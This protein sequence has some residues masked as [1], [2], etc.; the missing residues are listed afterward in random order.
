MVRFAESATLLEPGAPSWAQR[1]GLRLDQQ[2]QPIHPHAPN[3]I[4]ASEVAKLPPASMWRNCLCVVPDSDALVWSDGVSWI[5]VSGGLAGPPGADSTVPGPAGPPGLTGPPGPT[6]PA[7]TVPGPEGPTGPAGP[8]GADST[9][10]GPAGPKGDTGATGATGPVSTVPGPA[11]PAGPKGDTGPTGAD[12]TVPGPAGPPGAIGPKG[13]TGATGAASTVTGPPGATGPAGVAGPAGPTGATGPAGPVATD[14]VLAPQFD[15]DTSIASTAWV[16]RV[17]HQYSSY[18]NLFANTTLTAAHIGALIQIDG[19][20][21]VLTL[22]AT[23]AI[24]PAAAINFWAY[25]GTNTAL[26]KRQ[27]GEGIFPRSACRVGG[28]CR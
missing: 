26:F 1:L 7:S 15:N 8:K 2:F 19:A 17:G 27:R 11:G 4:Y 6:G 21:T 3:E 25:S 13:D 10:P 9:V 14:A 28:A 22:P 16:N 20:G 5:S 23:G 18:Q 24:R 12:S